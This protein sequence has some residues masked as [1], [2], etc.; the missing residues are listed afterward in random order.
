MF[1]RTIKVLLIGAFLAAGISVVTAADNSGSSE[2]K[3]YVTG[4]GQTGKS[5]SGNIVSRDK[6]PE[7]ELSSRLSEA[8]RA[9]DYLI[10]EHNRRIDMLEKRAEYQDNIKTA[11]R[12]K[13]NYTALFNAAMN[14]NRRMIGSLFNAEENNTEDQSKKWDEE[15]VPQIL[16]KYD[17]LNASYK[18][19]PQNGKW[20]GIYRETNALERVKSLYNPTTDK[21]PNDMPQVPK[22]TKEWDKRYPDKPTAD[23]K[24]RMREYNKE[25]WKIGYQML[26]DIY[27]N[28]SFGV[29]PLEKRNMWADQKTRYQ[30]ELYAPHY[31]YIKSHYRACNIPADPVSGGY[32]DDK[33]KYDYYSH[34]PGGAFYKAHEAYGQTLDQID[35]SSHQKG[36]CCKH[37]CEK[38]PCCHVF[39]S[40]CCTSGIRTTCPDSPC[41]GT[42]PH[43]PVPP[44]PL[45]W[46]GNQGKAS[47]AESAYIDAPVKNGEYANH[48]EIDSVGTRTSQ[49]PL[50]ENTLHNYSAIP[51]PWKEPYNPTGS[52]QYIG[53]VYQSGTFTPVDLIGSGGQLEQIA[54]ADGNGGVR[55]KRNAYK[56]FPMTQN[57]IQVFMDIYDDYNRAKDNYTKLVNYEN[58]QLNTKFNEGLETVRKR[59]LDDKFY[60]V[61]KAEPPVWNASQLSLGDDKSLQKLNQDI[62]KRQNFYYAKARNIADEVAQAIIDAKTKETTAGA[63]P[64]KVSIRI[65]SGEKEEDSLLY[66]LGKVYEVLYY[67]GG[68]NWGGKTLNADETAFYGI[69]ESCS[70]LEHL[71]SSEHKFAGIEHTKGL[72]LSDAM[73]GSTAQNVD[74]ERA[75]RLKKANQLCIQ[76]KQISTDTKMKEGL[77]LDNYDTGTCLLRLKPDITQGYR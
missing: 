26:M 38:G 47:L 43:P 5:K 40:Y 62:T 46:N 12:V 50:K 74:M 45:I 49:N 63:K 33:N 41:I 56:Y 39:R 42:H 59:T 71:Q 35:E 7:V 1:N 57:R 18:A 31:A 3:L 13:N 32:T 65:P 66:R 54:E 36:I 30:K 28:H 67:F 27:H 10:E 2:N 44:R 55:F 58:P 48:Y 52:P 70:K 15:I 77:T 25:R 23:Y 22:T 19:D 73:A 37:T 61:D 29:P 8:E 68:K 64:S 9:V 17:R 11:E 16:G 75:E 20:W 60:T 21:I 24:Y 14:C 72:E 76:R 51:Q 6:V 69:T 53:T 4:T 34:L